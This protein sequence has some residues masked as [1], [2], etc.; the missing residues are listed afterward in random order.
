MKAVKSSSPVRPELELDI[1][2]QGAGRE[3]SVG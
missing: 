1:Q 2:K 3:G